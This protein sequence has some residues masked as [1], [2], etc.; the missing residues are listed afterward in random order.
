MVLHVYKRSL[1]SSTWCGKRGKSL[2][3]RTAELLVAG[4]SCT[5]GNR[6]KNPG[7]RIAE[8]LV[9]GVLHVAGERARESHGTSELA[10]K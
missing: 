9:I 3:E 7:E 1:A 4:S 6:G 2:R 8:L 5:A 10:M